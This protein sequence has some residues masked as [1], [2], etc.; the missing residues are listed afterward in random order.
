MYVD[1]VGS[2]DPL[3]IGSTGKA[4][5]GLL[6]W[7]KMSISALRRTTSSETSPTATLFAA[8]SASTTTCTG[9]ARVVIIITT[10]TTTAVHRSAVL[11]SWANIIPVSAA[12][13]VDTLL[14]PTSDLNKGS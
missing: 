3:A 10:T 7:S 4:E 8:T 2:F 6:L 9:N 1:V 12:L 5:A 13:H 11:S 14:A